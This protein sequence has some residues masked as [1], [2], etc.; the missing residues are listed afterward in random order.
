M[1]QFVRPRN[2]QELLPPSGSDVRDIETKDEG[3][4]NKIEECIEV[5]HYAFE[6]P[7]RWIVLWMGDMLDTNFCCGSFMSCL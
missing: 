2:S 6:E 5:S 1:E 7:V 3:E 4:G